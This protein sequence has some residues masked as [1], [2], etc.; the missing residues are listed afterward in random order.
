MTKTA[1]VH[2]DGADIVYDYVGSGPLLLTIAGGGGSAPRYTGISEILKDEY[3]VVRYDRRCNSRSTGD[4][5]RPMDLVQQARDAIAIIKDL[6]QEKAYIFGNSGGSS[7]AIKLAEHY[8]E[9]ILGMVA[10]EP[11][12]LAIL[13]D[14]QEWIL[15]DEKVDHLYR[16][17]GPGP[18]MGFFAGSLVG[19]ENASNEP[20]HRIGDRSSDDNMDHFLENEFLTFG[21]YRPDLQRIKRNKVNMI[22]TRGRLSKDV[23]YAR[24]AQ[25]IAEAVGC[26]VREIS[27]NHIAFISDPATFAAELRPMLSELKAKVG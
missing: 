23:Y 6:G 17:Q 3:T 27:G 9:V 15:F 5:T 24:T 2:T 11:A 20:G 12:T 10:H 16:T 4:R 7:V 19:F 22:T 1:T 18:A 25:V 8:P 14:A 21:F 26:P 13:P